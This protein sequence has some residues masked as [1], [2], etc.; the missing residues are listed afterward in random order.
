MKSRINFLCFVF[1]SL[2]R[3]RRS[4]KVVFPSNAISL[5]RIFRP[6]LTCNSKIL[7]LRCSV[8]CSTRA[9]TRVFLKPLIF[10]MRR[11]GI[12]SFL[13]QSF[14]RHPPP[15]RPDFILQC[16]GLSLPNPRYIIGREPRLLLHHQFQIGFLPDHLQKIDS[17]ITQNPLLPQIPNR[18][19]NIIPGNSNSIATFKPAIDN[20][21][22]P[23]RYFVP[24]TLISAIVYSLLEL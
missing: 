2:R 3:R 23:S 21:A 16:T 9:D 1:L 4:L 5:I 7:W 19:T 20:K 12:L 14:G 8:S 10:V 24:R 22:F 18:L 6:L 13:N 15:Q 17:N 11:N